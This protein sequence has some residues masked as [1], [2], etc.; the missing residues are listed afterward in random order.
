MKVPLLDVRAQNAP[1]REAILSA[2]ASVMDSGAFILGPEVAAF[3][4]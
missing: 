1:L 4:K 3:E 2:V